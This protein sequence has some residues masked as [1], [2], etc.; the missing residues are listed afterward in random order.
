MSHQAS[1]LFQHLNELD[2]APHTTRP[3]Q[4]AE[5]TARRR[6]P[7]FSAAS[8][9]ASEAFDVVRAR[10]SSRMSSEATQGVRCPAL[11][12]LCKLFTPG[13][14][15]G[16]HFALPFLALD[17]L[18][19]AG[20]GCS[21]RGHSVLLLRNGVMDKWGLRSLDWAG[22]RLGARSQLALC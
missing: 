14:E 3:C 2:A 10:L 19:L 13:A 22:G 4:L 9:G 7:D 20:E 11:R 5:G 21:M 1:F 16:A 18:S 8:G 12:C 6:W 15:P 17:T